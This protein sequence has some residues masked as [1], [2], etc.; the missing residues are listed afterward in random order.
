MHLHESLMKTVHFD[1]IASVNE[2]IGIFLQK[3]ENFS[4]LSI[5]N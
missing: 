5:S 1:K 4:F 2:N 3:I